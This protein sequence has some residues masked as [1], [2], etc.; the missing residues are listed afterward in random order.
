VAPFLRTRCTTICLNIAPQMKYLNTA[1]DTV[2]PWRCIQS[3]AIGLSKRFRNFF[4]S[5]FYIHVSVFFRSVFYRFRF[6]FVPADFYVSL[7]VFVNGFI[8]CPL[9]DIS[10]SVS[11]NWN[12]ALVYSEKWMSIV[13]KIFHD[14]DTIILQGWIKVKAQSS[15]LQGHTT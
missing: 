1:P 6:V 3:T 2:A 8:I 7:F 15:T 4:I 5:F 11:V 12:H 14:W 13:Q 10:V 9:T